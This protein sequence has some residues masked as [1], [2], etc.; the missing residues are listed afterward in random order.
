MVTNFE[1]RPIF[2][3]AVMT[4][5]PPQN[6]NGAI[7]AYE[8]TYH[9]NGTGDNGGSVVVA[10]NTT[11]VRSMLT[12]ELAPSIAVYDIVVRAYNSIGPGGRMVV[13]DVIIPVQPIPREFS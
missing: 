10:V 13:D 9:I 4:W 11:D 2:T 12:L 8:V 5:D 6:P 3:S 7:T 1:A